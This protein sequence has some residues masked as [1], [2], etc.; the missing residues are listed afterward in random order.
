ME[1]GVE[2]LAKFNDAALARGADRVR[3]VAT[4]AVRET[5]NGVEF[6]GWLPSVRLAARVPDGLEEARLIHLGGANG[7]PLYDRVACIVESAAARPSSWSPTATGR[8]WSS[9]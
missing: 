3:A 2:A 5:D 8:I 4:S 7:Y 6:P 9:R 1:R